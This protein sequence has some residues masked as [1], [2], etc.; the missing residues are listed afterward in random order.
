MGRHRRKMTLEEHADAGRLLREMD[1]K[2]H[3]ISCTPWTK[4]SKPRRRWLA[5]GRA[6]AELKCALDDQ[7]FEEHPTEAETNNYY[8]HL[9][10]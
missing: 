6:I 8:G 3:E 9:N 4:A 7:L 10:A 1:S 5:V 2:L